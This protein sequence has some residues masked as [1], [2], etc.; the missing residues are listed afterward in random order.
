MP[1]RSRVPRSERTRNRILGNEFDDRRGDEHVSSPGRRQDPRPG[2]NADVVELLGLDAPLRRSAKPA[3]ILTPITTHGFDWIAQAQRT[4]AAGVSNVAKKPSPAVSTSWPREP[5][6]LAADFGVMSPLDPP[7][8]LRPSSDRDLGRADDVGEQQA[9][10]VRPRLSLT[11]EAPS[12]SDASAPVK[13]RAQLEG[14]TCG[15]VLRAGRRS[16]TFETGTG[17]ASCT[18]RPQTSSTGHRLARV[19]D[20]DAFLALP[21]ATPGGFSR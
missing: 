12:L 10:V 16:P 21:F 5:F 14:S 4:P 19:D 13:R 1:L 7:P 15:S 6:Q 2:G 11:P 20:G 9:G 18:G 17:S 3:R 8:R